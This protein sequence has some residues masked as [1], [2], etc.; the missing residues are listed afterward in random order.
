M[1]CS[2]F[3]RSTAIASAPCRGARTALAGCGRP[4]VLG[5]HLLP[6]TPDG[7]LGDLAGHI[8]IQIAFVIR[9]LLAQPARD[10]VPRF[11]IGGRRG[12]DALEDLGVIRTAQAR[13]AKERLVRSQP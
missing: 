7:A 1:N 11:E 5:H 13:R 3:S 4:R 10:D 8:A 6:L 12:L 2:T 9:T